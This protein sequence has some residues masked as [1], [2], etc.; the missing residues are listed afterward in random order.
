MPNV[1]DDANL[2]QITGEANQNLVTVTLANLLTE[3]QLEGKTLLLSTIGAYRGADRDDVGYASI[4]IDV[5]TTTPVPVILPA[6]ENS[7]YH[8]SFDSDY[9]LTIENL[10]LDL[11]TYTADVVFSILENGKF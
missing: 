11:E 6:F 9:R 3:E 2:F 7:V 5:P 8:G 10:V 1:S 4:L